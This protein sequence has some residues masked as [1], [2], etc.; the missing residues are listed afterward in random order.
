MRII[1]AASVVVLSLTSSAHAVGIGQ[2][3]CGHYLKIK[4]KNSVNQWMLGYATGANEVAR[5]LTGR[6]YLGGL[7]PTAIYAR[8]TDYCRT[9]PK[10]SIQAAAQDFLTYLRHGATASATPPART[11]NN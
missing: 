9:N 2:I 7:P 1:I 8:V 6:N 4:N 10:I 3:T 11:E 5:L